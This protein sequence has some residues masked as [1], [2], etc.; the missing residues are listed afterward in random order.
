MTK[1]DWGDL[2]N[3]PK[4]TV[5][6]DTELRTSDGVLF[7]RTRGEVELRRGPDETWRLLTRWGAVPV[8]AR[9]PT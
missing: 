3:A 7:G 2:A 4:R 8:V 1:G 6:A 9:E 5:P